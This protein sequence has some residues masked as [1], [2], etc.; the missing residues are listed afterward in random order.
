MDPG[1]AWDLGGVEVIFADPQAPLL[2][3]P[4]IRQTGPSHGAV[5]SEAVTSASGRLHSQAFMLVLLMFGLPVLSPP[6]R[7]AMR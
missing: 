6:V 1:T 7:R 5:V 2:A 4:R 3:T